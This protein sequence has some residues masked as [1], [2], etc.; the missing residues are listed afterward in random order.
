MGCTSDKQVRFDIHTMYKDKN[1]PM[2][3]PSEY[4][5]DF[6]KEAFMAINLLRQDPKA[7]IAELRKVK[8]KFLRTL[9]NHFTFI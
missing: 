1:L 2:P 4:E 5:N 3:Q 7:F 6:E 9:I 8:S